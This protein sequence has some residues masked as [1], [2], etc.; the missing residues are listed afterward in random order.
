[1]A[2]V[3]NVPVADQAP[4]SSRRGVSMTKL[5]CFV[6]AEA[7]KAIK[8]LCRENDIEMSLLIDLC[9]VVAMHSGSARKEGVIEDISQ[10]ID[11]LLERNQ[12]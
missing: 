6:D 8:K 2:G 3:R 12:E 4:D 11:R 9:E 7:I 10:C 5:A 1:M